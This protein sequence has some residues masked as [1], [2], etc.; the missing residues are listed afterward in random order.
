MKVNFRLF[1]K[2]FFISSRNYALSYFFQLSKVRWLNFSKLAY[3]FFFLV[4]LFLVM[5]TYFFGLEKLVV[6]FFKLI[7]IYK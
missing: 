6:E 1:I 4:I 3:L 5:G 2:R 7:K